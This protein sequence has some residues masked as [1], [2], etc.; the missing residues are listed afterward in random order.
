MTVWGRIMI[1]EEV[2]YER[3][4]PNI[5]IWWYWFDHLL[6]KNPELKREWEESIRKTRER[7]M[8]HPEQLL[9]R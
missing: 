5:G 8:K 7:T 1:G 3:R 6:D 2:I 4:A 9:R